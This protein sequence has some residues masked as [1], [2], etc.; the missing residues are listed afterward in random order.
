VIATLTERSVSRPRIKGEI[1][2]WLKGK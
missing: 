1:A 2:S